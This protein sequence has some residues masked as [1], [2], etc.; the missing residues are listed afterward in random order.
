MKEYLSFFF[1]FLIFCPIYFKMSSLKCRHAQITH[2][3]SLVFFSK[4]IC[5]GQGVGGCVALTCSEPFIYT[6]KVSVCMRECVR[7][8]VFTCACVHT[9]VYMCVCAYMCLHVRVCIHVFTC[10]CVHTC[11]YMCVCACVYMCVCAYMCLHVRVCIHVCACLHVHWC[12]M[13]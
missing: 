3:F 11:V 2:F 8:H 9:C 10:A 6:Y 7:A 13:Q 1:L 5:R 4:V 12:C